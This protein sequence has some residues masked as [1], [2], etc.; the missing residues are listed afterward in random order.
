[1]SI[2]RIDSSKC[3]SCTFAAAGECPVMDAC[4]MDVIRLDESGKPLFAYPEDCDSCFMC[5]VDCPNGA[6]EVSARVD[7]PFLERW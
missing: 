2:K 1:M 3:E 7:L 4:H 5:E 6:V